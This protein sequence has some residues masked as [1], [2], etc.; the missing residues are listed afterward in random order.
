MGRRA[1]EE[2][3][4]MEQRKIWTHFQ[5]PTNDG[6]KEAEARYAALVALVER[7]AMTGR[8]LNVGIGGGGVERRL[9]DRG[10]TVASLDPDEDAVARLRADGVDARQGFLRQMPFDE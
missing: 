10:W 2:R 6:F 7:R 4:S 5:D 1:R 3:G 8:A 9:R